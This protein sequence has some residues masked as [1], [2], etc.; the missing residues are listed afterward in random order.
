MSNPK[1]ETN[2]RNLSLIC[3]QRGLEP[4]YEIE[5]EGN[6]FVG[7]IKVGDIEIDGGSKS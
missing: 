1:K 2:V 6:N 5:E 4:V 7:T 3:L